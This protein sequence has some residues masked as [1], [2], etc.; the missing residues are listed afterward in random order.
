[1][2]AI[3]I[4]MLRKGDRRTL[5]RAITLVEST[6]PA[7]RKVANGLIES[8]LPYSGNSL[9]LGISG[10][11]G[12]G[13]STFV[14]ALGLCLVEQGHRVA[15][16]AVDPSSP[17]SGGS[18][19]GDKT[20]MAELSKSGQAYI[21]P[22]PSAGESG[23]VA[24]RTREAIL[25][26]EAAGFDVVLI[27]TV[28]VGQIEI[29]VGSM[30]DFYLLL[31]LP[32]AGDEV[33]GIKKGIIEVVDAIFINKADGDLAHQAQQTRMHYL[34]AMQ[35]LHDGVDWQHRVLCCSALEG[36]N[37][38]EGWELISSTVKKMRE[39]GELEA[40]RAEQNSSWMNSLFQ[41]AIEQR[42]Q[43]DHRLSE[44]S[45]ALEAKV[46]SGE[47]NPVSAASQLLDMFL[48][49]PI[50]EGQATD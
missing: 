32:A 13:K 25:L 19:M 41:Q 33:Q 22:S 20:R 11:P 5:A 8:V 30:V 35:I 24:N 14:E 44:L 28:G 3:N 34:Q 31:M 15:V 17:L 10:A 39:S 46:R 48:S 36:T 29:E 42:L 23:G 4:D 18:I 27:E 45:K 1:M 12:V 2:S 16:L 6:T 40:R 47:I 7:D 38:S 21:R 26:C 37:I 50:P 49:P 43:S 9:R